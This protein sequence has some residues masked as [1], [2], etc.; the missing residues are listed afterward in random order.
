MNA[1]DDADHPDRLPTLVLTEAELI[2]L[3]KIPGKSPHDT[4]KRCIAGGLRPVRYTQENRF[5]LS[6]VNRWLDARTENYEP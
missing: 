3:L 5:T 4:I 1:A 6:E 2:E